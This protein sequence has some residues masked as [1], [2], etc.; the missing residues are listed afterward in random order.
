MKKWIAGLVQAAVLTTVSLNATADQEIVRLATTTSTYNSGLL[1]SLLPVFEKEND[2]TVQVIAV[3]TGKALRMGQNGDV[4]L[5]MTHA[6]KAEQKFVDA[7]Y[8]V[9]P[10]PLMYNDFVLVG[11]KADPAKLKQAAGVAAAFK[12]L[13]DNNSVFISRGDDSGTHKKELNLWSGADLKPTFGNYREVGQ[14]MGK[15]LQ[16]TNEL[17]GYTM[18]DR[19]TW[20]AYES[21]LDLEIVFEGDKLLFNPY[22]V[23]LVNPER[24]NGLNVGGA[25]KLQQWLV[26]DEGQKAIDGF[27]KNGKVLF[28]ASAH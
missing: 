18:T 2:L 8:G 10:A 9:K 23:I 17:Q 14:G 22:Q 16:M 4:D 7:G 24:H 11:P 3:G 26:S 28:H 1:D 21:K 13:A 19:G 6:P 27:R 25:A 12:A 20:L 15:V 5:V